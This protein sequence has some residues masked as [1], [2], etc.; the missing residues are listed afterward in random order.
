MI[1]KVKASDGSVTR[2]LRGAAAE[3]IHERVRLEKEAAAES[4]ARLC[5]PLTMT[6]EQWNLAEAT[7]N[8]NEQEVTIQ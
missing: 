2:V 8:H 1:Y 3:Y 4:Y 7:M 6:L 5:R